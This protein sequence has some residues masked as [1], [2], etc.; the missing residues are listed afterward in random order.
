MFPSDSPSLTW[1]GLKPLT[2]ALGAPHSVLIITL[3]RGWY[4]KSYPKG[5]ASPGCSQ[6]P[7]T[8]NVSPSSRAKPPEGTTSGVTLILSIRGRYSSNQQGGFVT[9]R[10]GFYKMAQCPFD[11]PLLRGVINTYY[12]LEFI[13][14]S[15]DVSPLPLPDGSPIQLIIIWPLPRQCV[16]WGFARPHFQYRSTGSTIWRHNNIT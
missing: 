11:I 1:A 14:Q 12:F 4:Q 13:I 16:V 8:S 15:A 10:G 3:C 6:L 2:R 7:I 9:G 5:T